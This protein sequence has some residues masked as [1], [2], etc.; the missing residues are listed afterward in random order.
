MELVEIKKQR[1]QTLQLWTEWEKELK[2]DERELHNG[3]HGKMANVLR[4]E[5]FTD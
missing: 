2:S 5:A 3:L 4:Q 1:I